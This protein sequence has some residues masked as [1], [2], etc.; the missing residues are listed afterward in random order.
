VK[1]LQKIHSFIGQQL[2]SYHSCSII[3]PLLLLFITFLTTQIRPDAKGLQL[4][5]PYFAW[6][7]RNKEFLCL[8]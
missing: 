3:T 7:V 8:N 6:D 2:I 4:L 5:V 1:S